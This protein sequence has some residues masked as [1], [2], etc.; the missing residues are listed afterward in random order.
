MKRTD[1]T[2]REKTTKRSRTCLE[3][4]TPGCPLDGQLMVQGPSAATRNFALCSAFTLIELLVVIA[5]IAI[6]AA[7]LLPALAKAKTTAQGAACLSNLRQLQLCWR[8]YA[9][10]HNGL[11]PPSNDV[12]SGLMYRGVE[13][14]WAVGDGVHDLT[15]SNLT[16]GVLYPYNKSVGIY[17]CPGD[18]NTVANHPETLRTRT[19]QL[20]ATLN[21]YAN[22]V[23]MPSGL[24][25]YHKTKE[26]QLLTPPP[27]QVFT[28]IDP[29]PACADGTLFG[30]AIAELDPVGGN[31]WSSIPG[32]QHNQGANLAFADGHA[33][34][35]AWRW[36]REVSYPPPG[37]TPIANAADR[38]DWQRLA[39]ATAR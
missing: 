28:F 1:T 7:M 17:R 31:Q 8:L 30:V 14:S 38:S 27:V 19:Y 6:L 37:Y 13:P 35:F 15:T 3:S 36:S 25:R 10:D 22:G 26:S 11:M 23:P 33:Q 4:A 39:D 5:I 12:T 2:I 24:S 29:H 20:G 18:K 21:G 9:D 16:R 32:E 34:R